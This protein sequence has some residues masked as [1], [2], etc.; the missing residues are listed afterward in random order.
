MIVLLAVLCHIF[1]AVQKDKNIRILENVDSFNKPNGKIYKVAS[2]VI[3]V[4]YLDA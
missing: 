2:S 3:P 4:L 1:I